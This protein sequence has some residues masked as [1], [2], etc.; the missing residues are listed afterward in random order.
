[1]PLVGKRPKPGDMIRFR[2]KVIDHWG[3]YV[4]DD[5]VVH[6]TA[7]AGQS[8]L[9]SGS[10]SSGSTG[11]GNRAIVK[12]QRL[13]EVAAG[14]KY[15]VMNLSINGRTPR[16]PDEIVK[17][18]ENEVG[19][20]KKYNLTSDNCEHFEMRY[21]KS[22]CSQMLNATISATE[23]VISAFIVTT[24]FAVTAAVPVGIGVAVGTY[25]LKRLVF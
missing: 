13:E 7:D 22:A 10:G 9:C 20:K 1:M 23:G 5:F 16:S 2:G 6:L 11:I 18:A 21:G 25:F 4:G 24:G 15:E 8:S 12:R 17:A 14:R 3:V 19:K